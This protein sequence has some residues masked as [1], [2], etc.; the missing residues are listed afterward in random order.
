MRSLDLVA[1]YDSAHKQ[2]SATARA[3]AIRAG[4]QSGLGERMVRK[5]EH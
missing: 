4:L 3:H 5:C 1:F 2:S